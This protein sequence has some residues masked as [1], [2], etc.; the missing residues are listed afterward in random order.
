MIN[1]RRFLFFIFSFLLLYSSNI[2]AQEITK[3]EPKTIIGTIHSVDY[4]NNNALSLT[5]NNKENAFD[6]DPD[7]FFASF[8][9]SNTWVGIDLGEKHV[10]TQVAYCSRKNWPQRLEL[11]VFEGANN[12]DF[13]NALPLCVITEIPQDNQMTTQTVYNSRGFRYVRY[14]SPN[15]ARCNIADIEFYGYKSEGDDS[16]LAQTTN[17]PD[18]IIHTTD[19]IDITSKEYY[20][21]GT[22]SF[23]S[24]NGTTFYTDGVEIKGRGNGS[25]TFEKKPYRIKLASKAKVLD[26]EA[27]ARNWTLISNHGDK[28]LIRNLLA[29]DISKRLQ[30]P[31]TPA[32]QLVNVFL[33]GEYKG[34]YQ[35]CDHIDIRKNR[36]DIKE[37]KPSDI[38]KKN[39]TGGYLIEI[40]AYANKEDNWFYSHKKVPVT[41]KSPNNKDITPE[42]FNYIKD[43]FNKWETSIYAKNYQDTING[44]RRYTDT[45]TFLR[46]FLV[47]ELSGNTDTYWSVFM[48][49]QRGDDLFYFGPV[50][51]F[52]LAF[53]ND[54]RTYP[55]N[56]DWR[57]NWIYRSGGN[58]ANGV[59]QL[60]DRILS[61]PTLFEELQ[62]TYSYYRD[63]GYITEEQLIDVIDEYAE[64]IDSSQK[65]NFKRWDVIDKWVHQINHNTGSYQGEINIVKK[66]IRDRI[67]WMDNRLKYNQD[68]NNED[69]PLSDICVS[70]DFQS[71]SIRSIKDKT[72]IEIFNIA[73]RIL[74]RQ[75]IDSNTTIPIQSGAYIIKATDKKENYRIIKCI[76][77]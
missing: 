47:G 28:T 52:D 60:I 26:N 49:K 17:I 63:S 11:G 37:M 61:D 57:K 7:T 74:F 10:I 48:Y 35:L 70:T 76:V 29:F 22:I 27:E 43:H 4:D 1:Y 13:S 30:I 59:K 18:V 68:P 71:I 45:K 19:E 69:F 46:H 53:D 6:G 23:I 16:K 41:I 33:N 36:V 67:A 2:Q 40:D 64:L 58:S 50:W 3:L 12:P 51:D 24:N 56:A 62:K 20:L 25:W 34:C 14:V 42:Q 65:L 44:F 5:V 66:Y 77:P 39:I 72:T 75:E 31:Y 8:Q 73:G 21:N 32:C 38:Q 55:V 54:S 9:R 15:D